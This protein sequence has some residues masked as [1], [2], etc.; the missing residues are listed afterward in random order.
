[1]TINGFESLDSKSFHFQYPKTISLSAVHFLIFK[2]LRIW[3][4]ISHSPLVDIFLSFVS[5]QLEN[6]YI[7]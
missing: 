7:L 1:M 6:L 2:F 3:C 5:S 4:K